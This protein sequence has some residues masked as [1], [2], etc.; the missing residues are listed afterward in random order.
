MGIRSWIYDRALLP[1]T[2]GWYKAVIDRLEP[3]S[4]LLDVG[5]GTAGAL[6]GNA[7]LVKERD[8]HVTGVD[9]DAD[10]IRQAQI[11]VAEAGLQDSVRAELKSIYDFDE[12]GYDAAYFSASFML[13]PDPP[14]VLRYISGLL[15]SGGRVYFTQTFQ[16]RRSGLMEK[17]KPLLGKVTTIEFG[18]VTY[19]EDFRAAIA[20][21]GLELLELVTMDTSGARSYRLAVGAVPGGAQ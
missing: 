4:R 20:A 10:Y 1:L 13:M 3:G 17:A 6:V 5:I 8:L 12:K 11:H 9:I 16:D 7:A 15:A 19:E 18:R 14:A 2:T 21:G